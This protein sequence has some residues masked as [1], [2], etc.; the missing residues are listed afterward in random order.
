M[1]YHKIQ[2]PQKI[3]EFIHPSFNSTSS[4]SQLNTMIKEKSSI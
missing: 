1:Q 4:S 2:T 3:H